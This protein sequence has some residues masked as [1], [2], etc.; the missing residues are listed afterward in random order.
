MFWYFHLF[1]NF[2]Q[3]VVIHTVKGFGIVN[4]AEV[5]L[6]LTSLVNTVPKILANAIR[7]GKKIGTHVGKEEVRLFIQNNMTGTFL[8]VQWLRILLPMQ[9][10]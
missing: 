9:G 7:Q 5:F 4:K 3:F 6:A 1:K 10:A 2:P 8:V